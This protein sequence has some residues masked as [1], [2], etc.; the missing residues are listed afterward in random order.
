VLRNSE[1]PDEWELCQVLIDLAI[2][3]LYADA[4]TSDLTKPWANMFPNWRVKN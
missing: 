2:E 3:E 4:P 1:I